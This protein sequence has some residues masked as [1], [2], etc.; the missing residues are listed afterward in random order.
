[1]VSRADELDDVTHKMELENAS[2]AAEIGLLREK[3]A[4]TEM[5]RDE[6]SR[7][8]NASESGFQASLSAFGNDAGEDRDIFNAIENVTEKW[9]SELDSMQREH[10][11]EVE[12]NKIKFEQQLVAYKTAASIAA[13]EGASYEFELE[14]EREGH[15]ET[16]MSV[17]DMTAK[18]RENDKENSERIAE[19]L[20]ALNSK[21]AAH[22]DLKES[23]DAALKSYENKV[24]E[25]VSR[26][27]D[28]EDSR[29]NM[30]HRDA[31]LEMEH[32]FETTVEKLVNRVNML[33]AS[34]KENR[35]TLDIDALGA[36][37]RV[38]QERRMQGMDD[39]SRLLLESMERKVSS[40]VSVQPGRLRARKQAF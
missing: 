21:N 11:R 12:T 25:L 28:L 6:M 29:E 19:L 40:N 26:L 23:A 1:L 27:D 37:S 7:K 2:F 17:K 16:L 36:G 22:D 33:E 30:V 20:E 24:S 14:K 31:V 3:L 10:K 9:Q 5:E 32:L 8:L 39:K 13:H 18:L 38:N 34:A 35:E 15:L 4:N